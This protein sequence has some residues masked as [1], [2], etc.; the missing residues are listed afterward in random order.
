MRTADPK[1]FCIGFHKTG[2][3]SLGQALEA[4]GYRVC[5]EMGIREP[6]IGEIAMDLA[7]DALAGRTALEA[8][9]HVNRWQKSRRMLSSGSSPQTSSTAVRSS[10]ASVSVY[11]SLSSLVAWSRF[12]AREA[13]STSLIL[14]N[15]RGPPT[16]IP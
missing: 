3:T 9:Q 11:G 15:S 14:C 7:R 12:G 2:T 6:R 16:L 5:G 13:R 4:L 8:T 10:P 1:I